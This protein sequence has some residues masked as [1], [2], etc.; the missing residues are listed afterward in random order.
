MTVFAGGIHAGENSAWRLRPF[1]LLRRQHHPVAIAFV[2][3]VAALVLA[4][5]VS[6]VHLGLRGDPEIWSHLAS[7][8]LPAAL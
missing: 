8:V 2:L 3:A 4:P 7:Y 1:R 6:L 5:I